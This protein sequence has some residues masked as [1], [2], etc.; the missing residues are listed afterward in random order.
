M[1]YVIIQ[2]VNDKKIIKWDGLQDIKKKYSFIHEKIPEWLDTFV[3]LPSLFMFLNG[4]DFD[5]KRMLENFTETHKEYLQT[6]NEQSKKKLY[7]A[8]IEFN[9]ESQL[10]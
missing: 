8:V 6:R 7:D 9:L 4:S 1:F 2:Y 5:P 3:K 10:M